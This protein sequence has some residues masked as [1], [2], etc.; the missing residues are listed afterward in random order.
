M[1]RGLILLAAVLCGIA[2]P[3]GA[4]EMPV[5]KW[6]VLEA[7]HSDLGHCSATDTVELTLTL[8]RQGRAVA[9]EYSEIRWREGG[10]G[11]CPRMGGYRATYEAALSPLA[12]KPGE[13]MVELSIRACRD[14][15]APHCAELPKSLTRRLR[16]AGRRNGIVL[17]GIF[18]GRIE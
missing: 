17:G 10:H 12:G 6:H 4:A 13:Y 14:R 7:D 16:P 3:L 15:A 9:G 1:A 18:L 5:G 2:T 8:R 11:D